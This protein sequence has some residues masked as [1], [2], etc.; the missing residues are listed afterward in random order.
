MLLRCPRV[1]GEGEGIKESDIYTYLEFWGCTCMQVMTGDLVRVNT[2]RERSRERESLRLRVW[3]TS[4]QLGGDSA[5]REIF[6]I[7]WGHVVTAERGYDWCLV[8]RS[9]T[10][11]WTSYNAQ[12]CYLATMSVMLRLTYPDLE[13]HLMTRWRKMSLQR[14]CTRVERN[15]ANMCEGSQG[16]KYIK[17]ERK[18]NRVEPWWEVKR[19]GRLKNGH[20]V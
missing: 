9:Q 16:R 7:V 20:R 11:C 13:Y 15:H 2:L 18:V 4:S 10:Y 17:K 8:G 1:L 19:D 5:P 6:G 12:N 14:R 3:S